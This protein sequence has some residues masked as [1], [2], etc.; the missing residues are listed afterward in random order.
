MNRTIASKPQIFL[1]H[2]AGGDRNSFR[3]L[4]EELKS[5]FQIEAP[6]LP[7]RGDRMSDSPLKDKKEAIADI[8][9]Q[10][11]RIR[12]KEVPYLIYGH[13][14]GAILGFEICHAMEKESDA[15]VHFVATGYPGPGIKDTPPIAHLPKADFFA[16]VRKLGGISDEVMQYEELLDF[17]EPVLR[18]DFGLLENKSN[19]TPDIKIQTPVYAIMGKSE[20]YAL[21][22]RNWANYTEGTFECQIVNGNHFFINQ[23]FNYLSQII[24][25]LMNAAMAK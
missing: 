11:K 8:L 23:N 19:Q 21:N 6:E 9:E 25:N 15:P 14:M 22:I 5:Q 1:L 13:S 18:G 4:I 7:G 3:P 12:Q 20:K 2:Y 17:F 10:I 24:K 16:E